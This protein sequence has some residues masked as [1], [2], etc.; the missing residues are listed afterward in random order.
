MFVLEECKDWE[1]LE[2]LRREK[3]QRELY[4]REL[5]LK[6]REEQQQRVEAEGKSRKEAEKSKQGK[7]S[8]KKQICNFSLI[9]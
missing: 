2:L 1:E 9:W 6:E 3:H 8:D 5:T 7:L 4:Q